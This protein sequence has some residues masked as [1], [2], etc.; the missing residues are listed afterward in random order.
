MGTSI[1]QGHVIFSRSPVWKI[2]GLCFIPFQV[3]SKYRGK[4]KIKS[5]Y[6][7]VWIMGMRKCLFLSTGQ[8]EAK[9]QV[10]LGPDVCDFP[11]CV[12]EISPA[13]T[14]SRL[15]LHNMIMHG[16][17][18]YNTGQIEKECLQILSKSSLCNRVISIVGHPYQAREVGSQTQD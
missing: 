6:G 10:F 18:N 14:A 9:R 16:L 4:K 13:P 1:Y 15:V 3:I 8:L 5:G 12:W 11:Q 2:E 17:P 7:A